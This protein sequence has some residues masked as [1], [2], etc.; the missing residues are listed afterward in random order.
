MDKVLQ[1]FL[2]PK[3][4]IVPEN[5]VSEIVKK[6]GVSLDKFPKILH[7][8]PAVIEIGAKRGDLIKITRN[9]PTAGKSIYFRVVE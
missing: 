4:E 7:D 1:H 2:V 9:S 6:F 3:H 5:K 8:D